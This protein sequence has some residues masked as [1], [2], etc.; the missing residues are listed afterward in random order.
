VNARL[1]VKAVRGNA[2]LAGV[3]EL[4]LDRTVDRRIDVCIVEDDERRIA[5][6]LEADLLDLGPSTGA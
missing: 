4:G 6:E 5:A 1:D 2:G 3:A